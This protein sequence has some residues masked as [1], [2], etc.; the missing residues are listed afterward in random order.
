MLKVIKNNIYN[1]KNRY[2][3]CTPRLDCEAH[4]AAVEALEDAEA[5]LETAETNLSNAQDLEGK[6]SEE[7]A[8]TQEM[9]DNC[10]SVYDTLS[11]IGSTV[12]NPNNMGEMSSMIECISN[13]GSNVDQA[14][15]QAVNEVQRCQSEVHRCQRKVQAAQ[16]K[17]ASTPCV[18]VCD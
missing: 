12:A 9:L 15:H 10:K 16:Q 11:G 14:H 5:A 6:L 8:T 17:V 1:I 7:M 18:W 3:E 2:D 4:D 13:Y